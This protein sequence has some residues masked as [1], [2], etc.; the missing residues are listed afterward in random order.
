MNVGAASRSP[1]GRATGGRQRLGLEP[2]TFSVIN[3]RRGRR[4]RIEML[5]P[6]FLGYCF[7]RI[8][9]QWHGVK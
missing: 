2:A 8:E 6:L 4:R 9:L 1:A 3:Y 5:T 7:T